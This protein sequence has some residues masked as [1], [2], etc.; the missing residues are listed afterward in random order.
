MEEPKSKFVRILGE[1]PLIKVLDFFLENIVYDYSKSEI[2]RETGV[3][4]VTL[5]EI[6]ERLEKMGVIKKTRISGKA[7]MYKLN[8][9][10]E[11]ARN[12]RDFD[13]TIRGLKKQESG[14]KVAV[15]A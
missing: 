12:L 2:A 11:I 3:S 6:I 10:N 7:Q 9:D 15:E 1:S 13:L 5:Q 4:R 14:K 8:R